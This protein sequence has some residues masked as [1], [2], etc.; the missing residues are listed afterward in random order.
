MVGPVGEQAEA[1]GRVW[2]GLTS[3]AY[4]GVPLII[5]KASKYK[6]LDLKVTTSCKRTPFWNGEKIRTYSYV[7]HVTLR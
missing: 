7:D 1:A 5:L 3:E 4:K 6:F 2:E